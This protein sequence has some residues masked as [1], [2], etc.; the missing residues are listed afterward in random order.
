M[1]RRTR[2]S[3]RS[4]ISVAPPAGAW[5]ETTDATEWEIADIVAPPA[6]AWIET[7]MESLYSAQAA[8]RAPRG[9]VD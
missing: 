3:G 1:K 7:A 5:I 9:R 8:G 4:R 2:R 6:G